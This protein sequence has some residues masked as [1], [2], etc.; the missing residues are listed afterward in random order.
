M[1]LLE[2]SITKVKQIKER[3]NSVPP[4][5]IQEAIFYSAIVSLTSILP[6]VAFE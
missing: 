2:E 3:A 5:F 4:E 1:G 6:L